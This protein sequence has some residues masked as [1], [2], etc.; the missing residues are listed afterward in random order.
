MHFFLDYCNFAR[1]IQFMG[2]VVPYG[3]LRKDTIFDKKM[4]KVYQKL[5]MMPIEVEGEVSVLTGSNSKQSIKINS[6]EVADYE[7]GFA[8]ETGGFKEITFD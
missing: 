4:T 3:K 7:N 1:C 5:Q 8:S 6:V 2:V